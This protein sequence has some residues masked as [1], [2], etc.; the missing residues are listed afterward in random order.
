[1]T[2]FSKILSTNR[3]KT[4]FVKRYK[5]TTEKSFIDNQQIV[6]EHRIYSSE[7]HGKKYIINYL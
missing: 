5:S 4:V 3:T 1:M 7:L 6:N 2:N